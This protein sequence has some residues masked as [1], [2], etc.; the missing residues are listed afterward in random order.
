MAQGVRRTTAGRLDSA[1]YLGW[2][3]HG[4]VSNGSVAQGKDPRRSGRVKEGAGLQFVV[5]ERGSGA[6]RRG[7]P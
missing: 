7:L 1:A 5:S 6:E 3:R 4:T 2:H